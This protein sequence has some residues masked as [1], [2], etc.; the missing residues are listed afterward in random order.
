MAILK[1]DDQAAARQLQ[2]GD[3]D[4]NILAYMDYASAR[5]YDGDKSVVSVS[6]EEAKANDWLA[7]DT[8]GNLIEWGGYPGHYMT[9]V[10]DP[11][12]QRAWV[13]RAKE[14]AAEGVFD[15]IFADNAMYTLSHYNNAI[16]AGASSPEE[17]DARIRAGIL[18]LAR[19]AGEA[20]EGSGHSLMTNISDGRLDP[21]WWK[22]LSRYGGGMEE[23]FA[24]WGRADTPTVYD[25]GP[26]G[27]QDQVDLFE[28]NENPSVAITFAQEGDTRTALYGYTSFL[29]TAR[30]GDGWEVNFGNGSTKTAEQSIPLGAPRGKHVNSNGIRSREFDGGW[31]AVNPTD[32]AVTVQVPAGMVDASGNAVSSITLQ[33]RSGAVLSRS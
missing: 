16:M 8:N 33:P 2:A 11:G 26:G 1:P 10:W 29:M 13:E 17:S 6:F 19:Q 15:G 27:W 20:L 23:N 4:V 21:E 7:R 3:P 5:S 18:D 32:Q 28:M 24:N 22:A 30:P 12:Y 25:W 9:K 31:A 14:V